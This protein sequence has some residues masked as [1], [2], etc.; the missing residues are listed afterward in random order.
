M[1][2]LNNENVLIGDRIYDIA[3][4][5]GQVV[6]TSFGDIVVRFDDGIRITFDKNG[7]YGGVR[8]LYWHNPIV[9]EPTKENTKWSTLVD[10]IKSIANYLG[11]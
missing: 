11:N 3:R 5:T 6:D 7:N 4:G 9:I 1:P 2:T 10:C 8:R